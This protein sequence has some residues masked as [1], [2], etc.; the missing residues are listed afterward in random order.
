MILNKKKLVISSCKVLFAKNC[1]TQCLII[2]YINICV[3]K[4]TF[5]LKS[6][7]FI[8]N[9]IIESISTSS[10]MTHLAHG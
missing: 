6:I 1:I 8:L 10:E 4:L 3:L 2:V 5:Y 9:N 7:F